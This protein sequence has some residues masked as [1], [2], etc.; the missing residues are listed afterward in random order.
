MDYLSFM[1]YIRHNLLLIHMRKTG[2]TS[3][4]HVLGESDDSLFVDEQTFRRNSSLLK[5]RV[6]RPFSTDKH[7]PLR[8]YRKHLDPDYFKQLTIVS[9]TRNPWQRMISMYFWLIQKQPGYKGE[10]VFD[11]QRFLDLVNK[12]TPLQGYVCTHRWH[13]NPLLGRIINPL[14][15]SPVSLYLR[16]EHLQSDYEKLC[17]ELNTP[18]L[19]LPSLNLSR[20]SEWR[21][22]YDD[23]CRDKV[24]R[25]F[26]HEIEYMSY[27]FS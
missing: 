26:R 20:Y 19:E 18:P 14:S 12:M 6:Q 25:R 9:T 2:G 22:Y 23:E 10:A 24:A 15:L 3:L 4:E 1:L 5:G 8:S 11:K 27:S 17:A 7:T 21:T 13:Y 16:Q